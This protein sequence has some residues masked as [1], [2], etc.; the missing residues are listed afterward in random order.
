MFLFAIF[1][2][3]GLFHRNFDI[4]NIIMQAVVFHGFQQVSHHLILIAGI[5]VDDIPIWFV[6]F[7]LLII[8]ALA[9]FGLGGLR[10]RLLQD[11]A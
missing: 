9:L 11:L 6:R 7:L 8:G 4:Q 3:D 1:D 2:F 10:C 5:G